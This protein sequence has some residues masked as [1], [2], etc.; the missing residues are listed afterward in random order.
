MFPDEAIA[1]RHK[2]H[3]KLLLMPIYWKPNVRP[4]VA[5]SKIRLNI[6]PY[7]AINTTVPN[8]RPCVAISATV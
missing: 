2:L 6:R 4:C 7:V 8:I 3:K 5:F 1:Q